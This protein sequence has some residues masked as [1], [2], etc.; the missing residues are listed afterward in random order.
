MDKRFDKI[1]KKID[2]LPCENHNWKIQI[3]HDE[4]MDIKNLLTS[5]PKKIDFFWENKHSPIMLNE[6]GLKLY[7]AIKGEEFLT[8]NNDFF[9]EKIAAKNPKTPLDV[10][11]TAKEVLIGNSDND[12]YNDLKN[13]IY[14]SP[15]MQITDEN[16]ETRKHIVTLLDVCFV[17]GIALRDTYLSLHPELLPDT[18]K[19]L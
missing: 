19:H 11:L 3:L 1:D 6:N 12:I 8:A 13:W 14:F 15:A 17:L 7:E 5:K 2:K 16:G 10:E 9:L 18:E 4:V